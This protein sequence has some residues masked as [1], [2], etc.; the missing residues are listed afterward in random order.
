MVVVR[1]KAGVLTKRKKIRYFSCPK[2]VIAFVID[3]SFAV[4]VEKAVV[5]SNETKAF[6][7]NIFDGLG[8]LCCVLLFP[9]YVR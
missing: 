4:V 1:E 5:S 8:A 6:F 2:R 7:R 3:D 9:H